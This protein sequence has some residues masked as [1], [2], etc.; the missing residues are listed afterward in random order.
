[1]RAAIRLT[2]CLLLLGNLL[3]AQVEPLYFMRTNNARLQY[4]PGLPAYR[5][6]RFMVG[7]GGLDFGAALGYFSYN[8]LIV[9]GEDGYKYLNTVQLAENFKSESSKV[10]AD[11][12]VE[13]FD[14]G[15]SLGKTYADLS[16][17]LR[18]ETALRLPG[19]ALAYLME[20]NAGYVGVPVRSEISVSGIDY[21]EAGFTLQHTF[22]KKYRFGIRPKML[23][24]LAYAQTTSGS[25]LLHTDN[26]W[27]LHVGGGMEGLLFYPDPD[28][29]SGPDGKFQTKRLRP[30]LTGNSGFA[31]DLGA[32]VALNKHVG[33]S[34]SLLDAGAIRWEVQE[35]YRKKRLVAGLNP[36]SPFYV[37]GELVFK[38]LDEEKIRQLLD[39]ENPFEEIADSIGSWFVWQ[40]EEDSPSSFRTRL[41]PKLL[42]EVRYSFTPKHSLSALLRYDF[43][44]EKG[45]PT[46]TLGYSGSV[47]PFLD[48]AATYTLWDLNMRKN[49]L[50]AGIQIH[51][52][53]FNLMLSAYQFEADFKHRRLAWRNMRQAGIQFGCYFSFGQRGVTKKKKEED[54]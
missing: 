27:N 47:L 10:R 21:L 37:D 4:N 39:G 16:L 31:V 40:F 12:R 29:M 44:P 22:D 18:S 25:L 7:T 24:G 32:D 13:L 30:L 49:L 9:K 3:P 48:L 19:E 54:S 14:L 34:V 50:G 35:P 15:I 2:I 41:T 5:K 43:L 17:Q 28:G 11:G 6:C 1:M 8:D 20:G 53:A 23:F 51:A 33:L 46:V 52:G 42:A 26:D 38:G 45:I 36:E